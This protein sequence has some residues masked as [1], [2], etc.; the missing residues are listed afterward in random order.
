MSN[1]QEGMSSPTQELENMLNVEQKELLL[2]LGE[3][4]VVEC[5]W[6]E[7]IAT[8]GASLSLGNTTGANL[9]II[10]IFAHIDTS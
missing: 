7:I 5:D 9:P 8:R 6:N 10:M 4:H 2:S 1:C 3:D